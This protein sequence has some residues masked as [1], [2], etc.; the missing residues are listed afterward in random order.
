MEAPGVRSGDVSGPLLNFLSFTNTL[1]RW[2]YLNSIC[3]REIAAAWR[4]VRYGGRTFGLTIAMGGVLRP[5]HNG[6]PQ[7]P[8]PFAIVKTKSPPAIATPATPPR[9]SRAQIEFKLAS[10]TRY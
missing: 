1:C 4:E 3:A 5:G 6:V 9:S 8:P 2:L 7:D 10:G